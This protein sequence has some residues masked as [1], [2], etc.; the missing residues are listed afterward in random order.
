VLNASLVIAKMGIPTERG[1]L[2]RGDLD[3]RYAPVA[4]DANARQLLGPQQ[5]ADRTAARSAMASAVVKCRR[6]AAA[7]TMP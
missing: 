4:A 2:M 1:T 6:P 3:R 5:T 7:S